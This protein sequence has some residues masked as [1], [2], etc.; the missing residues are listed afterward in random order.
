MNW[1]EEG[2]KYLMPNY[3]RYPI[4]FE[5][6]EGVYLYDEKGN[7]YL[8]MLAGIAVNVLGYSHPAITKAICQQAKKLIHTSNLFYIKPQIELAK[9][10]VENTIKGK[11]FFCNSGAEANET[12]IKLARRYFFTKGENRYEIITF[13][14]GFHGRTLGALSA[15]FTPEYQEGFKPLL[16]GFR[17]AEFNS[18]DSVLDKVNEKTAGVMIEI[19]QGEGGINPAKKEF[20]QD[21]QNL[22][23]EKNILLIVDEVQT[24]IG[25]TGKLFAFQH[26]DLNPDIITTAKAL[27]GGVPIGAVVAKD[28]VS[29]TFSAGTHGSTFGGNYLATEVAKQV[30]K[31]V[32]QK[33]FLEEVSEKGEY[34]KQKLK[35]TFGFKVKGL[36]LMIGLEL[37]SHIEAK[38]IAKE[39]LKKGLIIGTAGK[40]TLRFVPPLIVQK[41]HIDEAVEK[42]KLII[43]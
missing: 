8:D 6:G 15:T 10:L 7:I 16:E 34:F 41:N 30:L 28:N 19:V 13:K 5:K 22:C 38:D 25:R 23:R 43:R 21:L 42:L 26:F 2:S 12:A 37:P 40:N 24:G 3:A 11:V 27:G 18:I 39:S 33:D 1:L 35:E 14:G 29:S 20:L 17:Y 4:L 36:G 32:N 9:I 31:I